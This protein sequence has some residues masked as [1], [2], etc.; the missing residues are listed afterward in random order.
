MITSYS[1]IYDLK[2]FMSSSLVPKYFDTSLVSD[3]NLGLL[4]YTSELV[5]SV[6]DDT[7]NTVATYMN[8][9]FPNLAILPESIYNY[10]ALFQLGQEFAT[11]AQMTVFL[12]V[13]EDDIIRYM[14]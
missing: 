9:M 2:T 12:F 6:T 4:G 5:A 8:E 11:P 3:L 14:S 1:S 10:G 13:A 7:F